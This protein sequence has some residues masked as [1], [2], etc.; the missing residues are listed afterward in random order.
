MP[1]DPATGGDVESIQE[2]LAKQE[3]A[4]REPRRPRTRRPLLPMTRDEKPLADPAETRVVPIQETEFTCK[5]LPGEAPQPARGQEEDAA[6]ATAR[7]RA[8]P[9]SRIAF[10]VAVGAGSRLSLAFPPVGAWPLAFVALVP[11][12]V[13][14]G[15]GPRPRRGFLLG[16]AFGLGF[17]GA[18]VYWIFLF[19]ELAW[20]ALT[21]SQAVV[22]RAVRP[23]LPTGPAAG[24]SDRH[25]FG[26]A[27]LWTVVEYRAAMAPRRV[28][29]GEPGGLAG[30]QPAACCGSPRSSASGA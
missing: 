30:R 2:I 28:H 24:A 15:T 10:L 25:G 1:P 14:A 16:L 5:L 8:S 21:L 19:G 27:A 11:L 13:A 6:A 18:T 4:S 29:V 26:V 23:G 12:S 20:V 7:E 3:A 22:R 17:F 9:R